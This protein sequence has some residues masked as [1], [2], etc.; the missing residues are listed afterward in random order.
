[1]DDK[2]K[3]IRDLISILQLYEMYAHDLSLEKL[4]KYLSKLKDVHSF[5]YKENINSNTNL[6]PEIDKTIIEIETKIKQI[7]GNKALLAFNTYS[8]EGRRHEHA[9][10]FA[11]YQMSLLFT[12]KDKVDWTK[13]HTALKS[14]PTLEG[15]FKK[16]ISNF[17]NESQSSHVRDTLR[18]KANAWKSLKS[19]TKSPRRGKKS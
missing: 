10:N 8:K 15:F 1:M 3:T 16:H 11:V 18:K 7:K 13:M 9:L 5:I 2:Y 4:N 19:K 14:H 12:E 6:V 17:E